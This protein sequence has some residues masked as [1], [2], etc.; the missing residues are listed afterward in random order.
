MRTILLLALSGYSEG[1]DGQSDESVQIELMR[2]TDL[3]SFPP[4]GL[5]IILNDIP[6]SHP[7]VRKYK[8]LFN[9]LLE[10]TGNPVSSIFPVESVRYNAD[11]AILFVRVYYRFLPDEI[12]D[13]LLTAEV[14]VVGYNF[15][16][17]A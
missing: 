14:L 17:I 15:V 7:D 2:E 10:R 3:P 16:R 9:K 1:K 5:D 8:K 11:D 4:V 12:A 6:T 13:I